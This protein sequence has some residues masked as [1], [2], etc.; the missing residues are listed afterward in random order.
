MTIWWGSKIE[1]QV[2]LT[3][4]LTQ[5]S[6]VLPTA[7]GHKDT[8][9]WAKIEVGQWRLK[10]LSIEHR[11]LGKCKVMPTVMFKPTVRS[12]DSGTV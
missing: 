11:Y 9:P 8:E 12:E 10:L 2:I 4:I 7:D 1:V 6:R 5:K 3:D